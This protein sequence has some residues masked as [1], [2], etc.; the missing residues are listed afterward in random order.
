MGFQVSIGIIGK[1]FLCPIRVLVPCKLSSRKVTVNRL[2]S[3]LIG[4]T[5][6]IT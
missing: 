1:G 5:L 6:H 3:C 2:S 4:D